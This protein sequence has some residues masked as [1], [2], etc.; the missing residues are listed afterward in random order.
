MA[1]GTVT[2][3]VS[4]IRTLKEPD[5][6]LTY[7]NIDQLKHLFRFLK[8]SDSEHV[9]MVVKVCLAVGQGGMKQRA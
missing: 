8:D 3:P 9:E 1:I 4:T 2:I 6:E 5:S 7:Y